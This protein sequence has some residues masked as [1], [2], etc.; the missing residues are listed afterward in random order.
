MP[1]LFKRA[2]RRIVP[3]VHAL[4]WNAARNLALTLGAIAGGLAFGGLPSPPSILSTA[5]T[6]AGI[7]ALNALFGFRAFVPRRG[8]SVPRATDSRDAITEPGKPGGW[9]AVVTVAFAL[10]LAGIYGGLELGGSDFPTIIV[11]FAMGQTLAAAWYLRAAETWQRSN[12]ALL[13]RAIDRDSDDDGQLF[14][15]D[16]PD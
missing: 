16:A 3:M 5:L 9:G 13:V 2:P 4:R 15:F 7:L 6:A 1:R 8:R 14:R 10:V 11:G 12:D